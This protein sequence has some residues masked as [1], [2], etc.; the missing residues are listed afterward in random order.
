MSVPADM[1]DGRALAEIPLNALRLPCSVFCH[2][3]NYTSLHITN[4]TTC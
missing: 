1:Q 2:Q 4:P 3:H